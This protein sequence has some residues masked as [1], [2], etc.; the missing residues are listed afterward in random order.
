MRTEVYAGDPAREGHKDGMCQDAM[1]AYPEAILQEPGG[2]LVVSER[3]TPSL[4]LID[5]Q[6]VVRT[7]ELVGRLNGN[8]T[9]LNPHG[10]VYVSEG[11]IYVCAEGR[12]WRAEFDRRAP[13]LSFVPGPKAQLTRFVVIDEAIIG[14]SPPT[15]NS[16]AQLIALAWNG[17]SKTVAELRA[18]GAGGITVGD[19]R[20][21]YVS[22]CE[23]ILRVSLTGTLEELRPVNSPPPEI[24]ELWFSDSMAGIAVN[25]G[26]NL[27]VADTYGH[28]FSMSTGGEVD[29]AVDA[30]DGPMD[31]LVSNDDYLFVADY[32]NHVLLRSLD[33]VA[34]HG[35]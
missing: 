20:L 3:D 30:P 25:G 33:R 23:R 27:F 22:E 32:H 4:R 8:D 19:D 29:I 21:L 14:A 24:G 1:F 12:L 31:V 6:G 28:V 17:A 15:R 34:P 5:R 18:P 13:R 11:L 10:R 35:H 7:Q 26:G 16:R 2:E 9:P